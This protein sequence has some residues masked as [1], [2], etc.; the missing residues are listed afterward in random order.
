MVGEVL[1][2]HSG[3]CLSADPKVLTPERVGIMECSAREFLNRKDVSI[4]ERRGSPWWQLDSSSVI[5][6]LITTKYHRN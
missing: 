1:P 2:R 3:S 4:R 5:I 6:T